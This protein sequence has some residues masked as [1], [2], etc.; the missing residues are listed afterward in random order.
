MLTHLALHSCRY[1]VS[2]IH[3]PNI[4]LKD[5]DLK[6]KIR[7]PFDIAVN[8]IEQ[9]RCD[10]EFLSSLGIMD[11]SLL[12]GVHNT[13]YEVHTCCNDTTVSGTNRQ[14]KESRLSVLMKPSPTVALFPDLSPHSAEKGDRDVESSESRGAVTESSFDSEH[15]RETSLPLTKMIKVSRVHSMLQWM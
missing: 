5:N 11:Y 10:A 12:L 13:E 1:T 15:S 14:S 3:E 2:G 7:L 8:V 4:I 9:L 6:F